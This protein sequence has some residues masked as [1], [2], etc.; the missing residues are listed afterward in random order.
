MKLIID[1][2]KN[3]ILQVFVPSNIEKCEIVN[4]GY[5]GTWLMESNSKEL[6]AWKMKLPNGNYE[7]IGRLNAVVS[8]DDY[9]YIEKDK[10]F[11]LRCI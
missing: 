1:V 9:S 5:A 6:N 7:V 3:K 10:N 11:I 8:E 4:Y 2:P